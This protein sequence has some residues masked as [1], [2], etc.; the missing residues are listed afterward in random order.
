MEPTLTEYRVRYIQAVFTAKRLL[1][2]ADEAK[3]LDIQSGLADQPS[4][5]DCL[6]A[7]AEQYTRRFEAIALEAFKAFPGEA[8]R[9]LAF[10]T[11]TTH[12]VE[13]EEP[14]A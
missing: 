10:D 1:D 9:A 5:H 3:A 14:K 12:L 2:M 13:P 11:T 6:V 8:A 4:A 7:A